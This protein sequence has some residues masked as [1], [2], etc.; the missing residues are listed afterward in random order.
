MQDTI[1]EIQFRE[2]YYDKQFT[3]D[4][5]KYYEGIVSSGELS[6]NVISFS[7]DQSVMFL[8]RTSE[9]TN[10]SAFIANLKNG[11]FTETLPIKEL[12]SIYNGAISPSGNKI[13]YSVR[14]VNQEE[15]YL[16][17]KTYSP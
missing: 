16:I 5:G 1:R 14:K 7:K 15:I 9:W 2:V 3:S 17:E 11:L 12:E 10:Q 4:D 8:T 6:E 13:I